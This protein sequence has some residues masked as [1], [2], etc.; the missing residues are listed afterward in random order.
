MSGIAVGGLVT[1]T[2]SFVSQLRAQ[3]GQAGP[4]DAG[5]GGGGDG[6]GG[7]EGAGGVVAGALRALAATRVGEAQSAASDVA[8]AAFMYFTASACVIGACIAGYW[9][10]PWL[11][12]GRYKLLLAGL[13]DDPKERKMLTVRQWGRRQDAGACPLAPAGPG[14][15]PS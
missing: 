1:S 4:D 11:P 12:Y 3:G 7:G 15:D 8:P 14:I 5:G 9:A 13:I 2:L 6:G 10:I